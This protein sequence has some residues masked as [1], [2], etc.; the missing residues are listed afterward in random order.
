MSN[1]LIEAVEGD[2]R[3]SDLFSP[4]EKAALIWAEHLTDLTFRENPGAFDELKSHYNEAQIVEITMVSGFFNFWN[5]FVDSL[6][7][8]I[9]ESPVMDLFTK[10]T[11]I[12]PEDYK[13][14]M[15]DCWWAD[16][17]GKG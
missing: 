15:R 1:E 16:G 17:G 4:A 5:R 6:Q 2:H 14:S 13:A 11:S 3:S 9:E 10:S 12:D 7:V 8:D